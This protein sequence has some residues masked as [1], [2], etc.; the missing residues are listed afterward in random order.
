[1]PALLASPKPRWVVEAER[2]PLAFAQVREDA[3]VDR[4]VVR[5]VPHPC[6]VVMTA[7]GGCTAA[8]L[9]VEPNVTRLTLVDVNPAQL[10]LSRL[11]L[12]LLL[13]KNPAE[14]LALL[15]H[16][17][18][19]PGERLAGLG[20]EGE[21]LGP[22]DLVGR[23]GP[24]QAGRYE[25]LFAAFRAEWAKR[26]LEA[27]LDL[28][29][30]QPNLE[31]LF[32][33]AASAARVLPH[34]RHFALRIRGALA[35]PAAA[36]NPYL[37]QILWG[38]FR[39]PVAPWLAA[40]SPSRLPDLSFHEGDIGDVLAGLTEEADVVHL[41]NTLDWMGA[42]R[43]AAVLAAARRALRPGGWVI[44]RQL[45]SP[46]DVPALGEGIDWLEGPSRSLHASDRSFLY[47]RL[48]VGR[49]V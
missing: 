27:A 12:R 47:R 16:A 29:F 39:G 22:A 11:K 49:R 32:P 26:P 1:M 7:S 40:P 8:A 48:W 24:D 34:A 20:E 21:A 31:A 43:A 35:S 36:E 45:N 19:E 42:D 30:A 37:S 2:L 15:G 14:R 28:T 17:P 3:E 46:L 5:A 41:S 33:M 44:I 4:W 9:A 10:A 23:L 25:R 18:M 13:E 38:C 6:R